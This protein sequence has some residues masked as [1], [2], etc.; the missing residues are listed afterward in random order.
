[1][2]FHAVVAHNW[3]WVTCLQTNKPSET[4][5]PDTQVNSAFY[6]PKDGKTSTVPVLATAPSFWHTCK[7][8]SFMQTF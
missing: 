7:T 1:M 6:P 5:Q 3:E 4:T 2:W 8:A